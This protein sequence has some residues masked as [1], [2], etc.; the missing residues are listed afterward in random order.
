MAIFD[1][2]LLLRNHQIFTF[3][4]KCFIFFQA[5]EISYIRK[6]MEEVSNTRV[7]VIV[8]LKALVGVLAIN[9][10]PPPSDRL[11]LVPSK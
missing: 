10:P 3:F 1:S 11:R 6:A 9:I 2:L 7:I 4:R 5:S 8:E